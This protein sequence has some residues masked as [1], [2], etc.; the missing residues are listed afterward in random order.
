MKNNFK[1][2]AIALFTTIS[3]VGLSCS[4][5]G[6]DTPDPDSGNPD[7]PEAIIPENLEFTITI[8]N[9]DAANP[10]G[11]GSGQI[12]CTTTADNA[13]KYG[14]KLSGETEIQNTTGVFNYTFTT[15]GTNSY[16]ITVYA[17]SSTNNVISRFSNVSV[18]VTV[19]EPQL[20]W[21]DEFDVDGS[22]NTA[23]W[24]AEVVPPDNGSWYNGEKQHYTDRLDNVYVSDGT[25]KIVAKKESYTYGTSTKEYTSARIITQDKFEFTYGRL[26]VRAKLPAGDGTWPAI[27]M[28]GANFDTAGWPA[29]G[30]IDIMEHWG[31]EPGY[32]HSATHNTACSGGCENVRVG[33]TNLPTYATEFHIYSIE[34]NENE[35]KFLID[36]TSRYRYA[37]SIKNNDNWP[38]NADQ[39]II[40]NVAMGGSWFEIDPNFTEA[41]MEVDYVRLYQ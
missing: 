18:Y 28:L 33:T 25:L 8:L 31:Y 15:P 3:I 12:T 19:P 35:I 41:A 30:E 7:T 11:D 39:F 13:V 4:S 32:V 10:G 36:G 22:F 24:T 21:S 17:Y 26:D 1:L 16:S 40:L 5:S 38:Y 27:W 37:P 20:V 6:S 34:W 23:N 14:F 2:I 9:A 29:C